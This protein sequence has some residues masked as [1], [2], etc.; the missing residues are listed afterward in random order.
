LNVLITNKNQTAIQ[1]LNI[2]IIKEMHGEFSVDEIAENFKNFFY[3]RMIIDI[4]AIK[5]YQDISNLQKLSIALDTDKMILYLGNMVVEEANEFLSTLISMGIYNF[6]K[7]IDG[8]MYLYNNPNTYRDVAHFHNLSNFNQEKE[9]VETQKGRKISSNKNIVIGIQNLTSS[10]GATSLIFM[11]KNHL[12]VNYSVAAIELNKRDFKYLPG[13]DMITTTD[14]SFPKELN[15]CK[16]FD[17]ILVD[18]NQ[19]DVGAKECNEIVY[20]IEPSMLKL[21]KFVTLHKKKVR[22]LKDKR[23]VLNQSMLNSKDVLDF[24]HEA[25]TKVFFNL[26]PLDDRDQEIM[27]LNMF[28]KK[29]GFDKQYTEESDKKGRM[30]GLF[31]I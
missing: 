2:E 3:Q 29:L 24:E 17:V 10:S 11:M 30:L 19:S 13:I 1:S 12:A 22:E 20:L 21:N 7:N 27:V 23:V 4:T 15:K 18:L 31:G 16:E 25:N 6:T 26:P 14:V 28:L 8:I 9:E 5:E